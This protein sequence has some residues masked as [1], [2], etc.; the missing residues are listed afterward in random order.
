VPVFDPATVVPAYSMLDALIQAFWMAAL[1]AV[2]SAALVGCGIGY[3]RAAR[4]DH[5]ITRADDQGRQR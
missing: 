3:P 2:L 1:L 4:A 5:G